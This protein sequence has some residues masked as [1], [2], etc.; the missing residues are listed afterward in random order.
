MF[1]ECKGTA[2]EAALHDLSV[3]PDKYRA[4][5]DIECGALDRRALLDEY[6]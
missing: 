4:A 1:A 2:Y 6:L 5:F 3:A